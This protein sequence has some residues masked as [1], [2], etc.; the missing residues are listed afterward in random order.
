MLI[1]DNNAAFYFPL[2]NGQYEV[3]PGLFPF[4]TDFGNGQQDFRLFQIDKTFPHYR[5]NKLA[6]RAE[7]LEKYVCQSTAELSF[8]IVNQFIVDALCSEYPE[9]FI[10][11]PVQQRLDCRLTDEQLVFDT[12]GNLE[13][14]KSQINTDTAYINSWDALAMQIQEDLAIMQVDT[15]GKGKLVA[16]HLCAPNHWAASDKIGKDFLSMHASVPGMERINQRANQI[17]SAILHKGPFVRFAWGFS[18]DTRLNHHPIAPDNIPT[19]DWQGRQFN[20]ST[21]ELYLRVERQ[22]LTGYPTEG[23]VLFTIR[24]YFYDVKNLSGEQQKQLLNAIQ[25][26]SDDTICYKG[27]NKS[28]NMIVNWLSQQV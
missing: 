25:S 11:D 28:K 12:Q 9:F 26:M 15:N 2:S 1:P 19:S 22:T 10:F 14:E 17:N 8:P 3:K 4:P 27:L 20:P 5:E 7:S 24:N 6:A 21:P 13:H 16:L 18:S 23:L